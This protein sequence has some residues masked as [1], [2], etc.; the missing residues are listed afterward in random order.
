LE[1]DSEKKAKMSPA[2][3]TRNAVTPGP[4]ERVSAHHRRSADGRKKDQGSRMP[5]STGTKNHT[6]W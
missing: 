6:G 4:V 2:Q 5:A 1:L 3:R